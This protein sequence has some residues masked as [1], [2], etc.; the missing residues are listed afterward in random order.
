MNKKIEDW[1]N[2]MNRLETDCDSSDS[3]PPIYIVL[4]NL[5]CGPLRPVVP[6]GESSGDLI[7]CRIVKN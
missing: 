6:I 2:W 1:M 7:V 4:R 3:C 5:V